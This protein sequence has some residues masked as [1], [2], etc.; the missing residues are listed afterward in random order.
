MRVY[1]RYR[2]Q[3]WRFRVGREASRKC[4]APAPNPH[5]YPSPAHSTLTMSPPLVFAR[6]RSGTWENP[7]LSSLRE[8]ASPTR[9]SSPLSTVSTQGSIPSLTLSV[10]GSEADTS[11]GYSDFNTWA[12][13]PK[14]VSKPEEMLYGSQLEYPSTTMGGLMR[15]VSEPV[16][17]TRPVLLPFCSFDH[18]SFARALVLSRR[19]KVILTLDLGHDP[20]LDRNFALARSHP[21]S[22]LRS[23]LGVA[24]ASYSRS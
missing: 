19:P 5:N 16:V 23:H 22:R 20:N 7:T 10:A 3:L 12:P 18:L 6:S 21:P 11:Q 14:M 9:S 8:N 1:A 2:P 13:T 4:V 17:H 15:I 24:R